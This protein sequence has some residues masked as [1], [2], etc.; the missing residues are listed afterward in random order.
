MHVPKKKKLANVEH[1]KDL[2][3]LIKEL[4]NDG[5]NWCDMAHSYVC[6]DSFMF[7]T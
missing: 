5:I 4:D 2:K 1:P 3:E 6:H 7:G